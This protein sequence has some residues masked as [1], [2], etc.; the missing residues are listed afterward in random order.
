MQRGKE[1]DESDDE[2]IFM[3]DWA[4]ATIT[5]T[6][7]SSTV[8]IANTAPDLYLH[9]WKTDYDVLLASDWSYCP[10]VTC[11]VVANGF[12]PFV[13]QSTFLSVLTVLS[14]FV[15]TLRFY[16]LYCHMSDLFGGYES[17]PYVQ[18]MMCPYSQLWAE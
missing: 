10:A 4:G 1:K 8:E 3:V 12:P 16:S 6:A 18:Y 9:A 13:S 5:M 15:F 17:F 7:F 14:L 11:H 2:S